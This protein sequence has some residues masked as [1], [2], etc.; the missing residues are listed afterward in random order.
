MC[1]R[2]R[3]PIMYRYGTRGATLQSYTINGHA[4]ILDPKK[5]Q[6]IMV[7][8]DTDLLVIST[9]VDQFQAT[10]LSIMVLLL[11]GVDI[12]KLYLVHVPIL[13]NLHQSTKE[14]R[15]LWKLDDSWN[16]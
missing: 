12:N 16:Q 5:Y 4:E 14:L 6:G 15:K 8:T 11:Y 3:L 2:P 9:V 13:P 1:H 10:S 7:Y